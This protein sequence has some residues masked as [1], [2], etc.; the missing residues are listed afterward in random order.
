MSFS[1]IALRRLREQAPSIQTVLLMDRVPVRAQRVAAKRRANRGTW[2]AH[3]SRAPQLRVEGAFGGRRGS[4]VDG[5]RTWLTLT[6]V[7]SS[8]LTAS[9]RTARRPCSVGLGAKSGPNADGAFR[10]FTRSLRWA[11]ERS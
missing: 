4:R 7:S 11:N 1:E 8:A 6:C 5:G 3:H 2:N 10:I 9:S